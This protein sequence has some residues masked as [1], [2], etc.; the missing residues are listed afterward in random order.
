L[1][2]GLPFFLFVLK[3]KQILE[4]NPTALDLYNGFR[5][6]TLILSTLN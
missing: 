4:E 3:L 2:V 1:F 6:V 5:L